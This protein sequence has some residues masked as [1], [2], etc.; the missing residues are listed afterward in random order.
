MSNTSPRRTPI[1]ASHE[2]LVRAIGDNERGLAFGRWLSRLIAIPQLRPLAAGDIPW[3][4]LGR[5]I[6]EATVAVVTTGGVHLRQ[7]KPF[8]LKGDDSYRV[9]PR[10]AS[11][12]DLAISHQAYDRTDALS[13]MNLVFPLERVR[14]LAAEG[15]IGRA[16]DEHFGFGLSGSAKGIPRQGTAVGRRLAK[17]DVDLALLVPA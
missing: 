16:A 8:N 9:I 14:E 12:D 13:D 15:V 11:A 10:D 4:P 2:R 6:S 17:A 1:G 3:H 5:P 7:D